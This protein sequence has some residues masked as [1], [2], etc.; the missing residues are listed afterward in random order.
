MVTFDVCFICDTPDCLSSPLLFVSNSSKTRSSYSVSFEHHV[1][2][3]HIHFVLSTVVHELT[4]TNIIDNSC[5]LARSFHFTGTFLPF[6]HPCFHT[7]HLVSPVQLHSMWV[8][9]LGLICKHEN[10]PHPSTN[11]HKNKKLTYGT[12]S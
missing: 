4:R 12:A 2:F 1:S 6:L 5:T 8:F 10:R 9:I 11:A 7:P 3:L